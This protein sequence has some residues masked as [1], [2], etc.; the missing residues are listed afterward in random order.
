MGRTICIVGFASSSRKWSEEQPEGV[1]IWGLNELHI[2]PFG[3]SVAS[4]WFQ[5]H[6]RNWKEQQRE[7]SNGEPMEEEDKDTFG[8]G[9]KHLEWLKECGIPVY[10]NHVDERI[11]TAVKYPLEQI[12]ESVGIEDIAGIKRAYLTSSPAFMIALALHEHLQGDTVDEIRLAGI[13]LSVGTE[14]F[15]QRPC[16]EYYI[17]LAKGM[18]IKVSLPPAPYA[19]SLLASPIYSID[20]ELPKPKDWSGEY[21]SVYIGNPPEDQDVRLTEENEG[22]SVNG[23]NKEA[24]AP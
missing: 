22:L 10:M 24:V 2:K 23:T 15:N 12:T 16:M 4:R 8:R 19:C 5:I 17:G 6:P 3:L 20:E 9:R 11:P 7:I 18:G 13:E 1:E 14:Y 21:F